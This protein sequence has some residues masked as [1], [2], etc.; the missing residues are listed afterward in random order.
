MIGFEKP[1]IIKAMAFAACDTI[2]KV[3]INENIGLKND[4][5]S[6]DDNGSFGESAF[7]DCSSLE[8]VE[9][10][11]SMTYIPDKTFEN[12]EALKQIKLPGELRFIGRR[13]FH[14]CKSLTGPDLLT[15]TNLDKIGNGAFE[16]CKFKKLHLPETLH[17]I[18]RDAFAN[19]DLE[20]IIIPRNVYAIEEY[21]FYECKQLKS[22]TYIGSEI[23]EVSEGCFAGCTNLSKIVLRQGIIVISDY[24]FRIAVIFRKL[25]FLRV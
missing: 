23:D 9:F 20:D 19:T 16:G 14:N 18:G 24:A 4:E 7:N 5:D 1:T 8:V 21:A 11:N 10:N 12:C 17:E 13:A 6:Y 15:K 25:I 2:K 3:V 22:V